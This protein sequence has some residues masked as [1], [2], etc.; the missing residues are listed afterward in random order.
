M[1]TAVPNP[2]FLK[3]VL[4]MKVDESADCSVMC[5]AAGTGLRSCRFN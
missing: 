1:Q 3:R 4:A 5:L 2:S